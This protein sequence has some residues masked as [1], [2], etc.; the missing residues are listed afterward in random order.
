VLRAYEREPRMCCSDTE[1]ADLLSAAEH[2][3]R[4][5]QNQEHW[6]GIVK[7]SRF[8]VAAVSAEGRGREEEEMEKKDIKI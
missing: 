4:K 5:S 6:R 1:Q 7:W 8:I 2:W 3:E